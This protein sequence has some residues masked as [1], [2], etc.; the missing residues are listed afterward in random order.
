MLTCE[1]LTVYTHDRS[2]CLLKNVSAS[3]GTGMHALIGPSGCGK[4]TLVRALLGIQP[5]E[6]RVFFNGGNVDCP[7][8]L[9][10]KIGFA[11]QFSIAQAK[12]TVEECLRFALQLVSNDPRV[13][14]E[15]LKEILEWTGLADHREK[16]VESL[17][18][19]QLRRL[20]LG[21]ELTQDPPF[22]ICDE[23]TSGLDPLS[24]DQ[25]LELMRD[26]VEKRGK[27]VLCIIHN[28]AKLEK[29]DSV[30]V[31]YSGDVVFQGTPREL[32]EY[33]AIPDSLH[34]YD[35][36]NQKPAEHWQLLRDE[37]KRRIQA[38]SESGSALGDNRELP[39]DGGGRKSMPSFLNQLR[40]LLLRRYLLLFR[41]RGYW[42][43]TLAITLGF[44]CLVVIFALGGL[45][46]IESLALDRQLGWL[47]QIQANVNYRV[48]AMETASLVTGLIMF[49]VI[50][51]TLMGSNNGAREI[52]GERVLYEKER[53]AGVNWLAYAFSKILF[54]TSLAVPQGLWM[55]AFVKVI[56]GF[57]GPWVGQGLTLALVC[58]S[59]SIVCLGFSAWLASP[60]KASL[61]SIYLVGFQLPLSGVVLALPES[62]V[63]VC[64]PFITSYWGWAGYMSTMIETRLYDAFRL[65]DA[66]WLPSTSLAQ[67]VLILQAM[68]GIGLVLSGCYRRA[69][70]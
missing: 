57:P 20:G 24:E 66:S 52:A 2:Q 44:P 27:T 49:Q 31:V 55:M 50:L 21:L 61:L 25:I 1:E 63:W 5:R 54:V 68:L 56:C 41:D 46:Q 8:K 43:L 17:S 32:L 59:M 7:E 6:G 11:P 9:V 28:L 37:R 39:Q 4:T 14:V 19:G 12:L 70:K 53:L 29:F 26:L 34:L 16:R 65:N 35:I 42:L 48:R 40:T 47:E 33:Y 67:A 69:W 36:L 38:S 62:L 51:L 15:R 45:P 60:E 10:G 18:G 58:A 23:V 3:F 13:Q 30:T 22:L 64:R